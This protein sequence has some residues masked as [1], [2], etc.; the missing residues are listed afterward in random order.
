[1]KIVIVAGRNGVF[2]QKNKELT[3]KLTASGHECIFIFRAPG[4][5][6]NI[7]ADIKAGEPDLLITEDL[8]GFEMC[9][10]TDAVSYN[11]VHC[12]QLHFLFSEHPINEKYLTK[13]LSLV[14]TFVCK[15]EEMAERIQDNYPDLPEVVCIKS[16]PTDYS[17]ELDDIFIDFSDTFF[18]L[19][20]TVI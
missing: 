13:Q 1:M 14:M 6:R 4:D 17:T 20:P 5:T 12:R 2:D 10:L 11:L 19:Q 15:D 9:T 18:S 16:A 8:E 3:Q 7:M